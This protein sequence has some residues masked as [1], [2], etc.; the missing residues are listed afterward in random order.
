[1]SKQQTCY[2]YNML[3][4]DNKLAFCFSFIFYLSLAKGDISSLVFCLFFS[5][6]IREDTVFTQIWKAH[7]FSSIPVDIWVD[8]IFTV[9]GGDINTWASH[10]NFFIITYRNNHSW[11]AIWFHIKTDIDGKDCRR[12]VQMWMCALISSK[13]T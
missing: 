3:Q 4:Y 11:V 5:D 12:P 13:K 7:W 2:L 10:L 9:H 1:M 6:I 8:Q